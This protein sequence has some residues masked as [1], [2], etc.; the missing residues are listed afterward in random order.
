L[1]GSRRHDVRQRRP[2]DGDAFRADA[3]APAQTDALVVPKRDEMRRSDP[4]ERAA[5]LPIIGCRFLSFARCATLRLV[6]HHNVIII[7]ER[8][9]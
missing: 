3:V 9:G 7:A 2:Q 4:T 8:V 6:A 1:D 5:N